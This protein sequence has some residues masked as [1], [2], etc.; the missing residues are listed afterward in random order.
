MTLNTLS[1]LVRAYILCSRIAALQCSNCRM[2]LLTLTVWYRIYKGPV[3]MTEVTVRDC[4]M[5]CICQ[6]R[7]RRHKCVCMQVTV[8]AVLTIIMVLSTRGCAV[9][10]MMSC[11]TVTGVTYVL[12]VSSSIRE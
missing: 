4:V 7:C 11:L 6:R 10:L 3:Y 8:A 1:A 9:T 2:T 5:R 12:I